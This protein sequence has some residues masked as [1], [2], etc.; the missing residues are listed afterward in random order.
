MNDPVQTEIGNCYDRHSIERWF[1][2]HDTD[3]LTNEQLP[4]GADG[5]PNLVPNLVLRGEIRTW[6]EENNR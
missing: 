3:P 1:S 4:N 2:D 6:R 5:Q